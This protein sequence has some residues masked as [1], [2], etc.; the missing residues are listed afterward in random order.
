MKVIETVTGYEVLDSRGNPTVEAEV[1]LSD[2]SSGR[3]IAPSG[4]STER[5]EATELRDGDEQRFG[6]KGVLRAVAN[7][8]SE[9]AI[10]RS[11]RTARRAWKH[12]LPAWSASAN[13]GRPRGATMNS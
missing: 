2:G 12:S 3:G 11:W 5:L 9:I 8:N 6:G 7:V 4:A 13:V 10:P 1:V